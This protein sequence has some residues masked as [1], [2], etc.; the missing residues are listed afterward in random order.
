[1]TENTKIIIA[2]GTTLGLVGLGYYFLVY[3]KSSKVFFGDLITNLGTKIIPTKDNVLIIPFNDD[4][5]FAQFYTN[6][7]VVI[8][9]ANKK[10]VLKGS[11]SDGGKSMVL[12]SGRT[13]NS[14]SVWGNLLNTI[15]N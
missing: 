7:R 13:I 6:N 10:V 2:V 4:K 15:T 3:K 9:D 5:N 1:M 12:D 11:Y 14:G 8:F